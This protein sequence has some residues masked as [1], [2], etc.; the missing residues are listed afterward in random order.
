MH[1]VNA[2]AASSAELTLLTA[3]ID[4]AT[5]GEILPRS[6][7]ISTVTMVKTWIEVRRN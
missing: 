5:F 7:F 3:S 2:N 4:G 6:I 1:H